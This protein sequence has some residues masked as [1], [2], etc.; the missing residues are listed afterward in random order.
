MSTPKIPFYNKKKYQPRLSQICCYGIF[1]W[2]LKNE[3]GTAVVN[4]LSVFEPLKFYCTT[5]ASYHDENMSTDRKKRNVRVLTR[6]HH[7]QI[8]MG[9]HSSQKLKE[10]F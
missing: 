7:A 8:G 9:R 2:G 3:F 4:E 5:A 10:K 1:S 6:L